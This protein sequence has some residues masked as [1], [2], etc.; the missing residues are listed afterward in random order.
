MVDKKHYIE[1]TCSAR[2]TSDSVGRIWIISYNKN[3]DLF[4]CENKSNSKIT[5]MK[6]VENFVKVW[7]YDIHQA[8]K[9]LPPREDSRNSR[10]E[11]YIELF[12]ENDYFAGYTISDDASVPEELI[13]KYIFLLKDIIEEKKVDEKATGKLK[14]VQQ[15]D[16]FY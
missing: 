1:L 16:N 2:L 7:S 11:A 9:T 6:N 8:I 10:P 15:Y 4:I 14:M 12:I 3:Q 5:K 13:Q